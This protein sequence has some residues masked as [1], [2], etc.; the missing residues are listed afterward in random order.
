MSEGNLCQGG[1]GG[2]C[3]LDDR[4]SI[5]EGV[6]IRDPNGQRRQTKQKPSTSKDEQ[7]IMCKGPTARTSYIGG[8]ERLQVWPEYRKGQA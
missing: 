1:S 8:N 2:Y 4:E 7:T 3:G 6:L 5:E